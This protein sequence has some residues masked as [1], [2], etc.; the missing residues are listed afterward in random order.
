MRLPRI[1]KKALLDVRLSRSHAALH[2]ETRLAAEANR[3]NA[4]RAG[5][6][7]SP[8]TKPGYRGSE[9]QPVTY[10][11]RFVYR[12]PPG[13]DL[14]QVRVKGDFNAQGER[15]REWTSR[16]MTET[17][18]G[19]GIWT[20]DVPLV[21]RGQHEPWRYGFEQTL[22]SGHVST[23]AMSTLNP[24]T[25]HPA[26]RTVA[27]HSPVQYDQRGVVQVGD[28]LEFRG[29][30]FCTAEKVNLKILADGNKPEEK[31]PMTK[32]PNGLWTT[33]QAH[34]AADLM[35]RAY[36]YEVTENGQTTDWSDIYTETLQG[37]A[38]GVDKFFVHRPS[39]D[40][41]HEY[42][43][44]TDE[45]VHF[46][47]P[48]Q[49]N[50]GAKD[51]KLAFKDASGRQLSRR[52]L[53]E[54]IGSYDEPARIA[55][56]RK[57]AF[58]DLWSESAIDE[59]GR[60]TMVN[61]NGSGNFSTLINNPRALDGLH[62]EFQDATGQKLGEASGADRMTLA[63]DPWNRAL[64]P[65]S[66]RDVGA[67]IITPRLQPA[68]LREPTPSSLIYQLHPTSF[69]TEPANQGVDAANLKD[70]IRHF[71]FLKDSGVTDIQLLPPTQ[72]QMAKSWSYEGWNTMAQQTRLGF[73][74]GEG[75][76]ARWV[77]GAEALKIAT[78]EA[79][80]AGLNVII[81]VVLNHIYEPAKAELY[82]RS[83]NV[84]V[85]RDPNAPGIQT[86]DTDWGTA[87]NFADPCVTQAF[88]DY[89]HYLRNVIGVDG[90][91]F[92]FTEP[93]QA[94]GGADMLRR[95]NHLVRSFGMQTLVGEQFPYDFKLTAQHGD[96]LLF[97]HTLDLR[98]E[99]ALHNDKDNPA[100]LLKAGRGWDLN[101]D[102]LMDLITQNPSISGG[103]G[104]VVQGFTTHD[105][106]G[107][108]MR[109]LQAALGGNETHK[110]PRDAHAIGVLKW[111]HALALMSPGRAMF[112][113][114]DNSGATNPF[115]WGAPPT[116][117]EGGKWAE[118][119]KE[120]LQRWEPRR[121]A[122]SQERFLEAAR[123]T[124][125]PADFTAGEQNMVKYLRTLEPGQREE[126]MVNMTRVS[127]H[128]NFAALARLRESVPEL[129][130]GHFAAIRLF[131]HNADGVMAFRRHAQ[132]GDY[133]EV[134]NAKGPKSNYDKFRLPEGTWELVHNTDAA[135]Y[136]GEGVGGAVG[137]R[138]HGGQ[139]VSL[140]TG[141]LVLRK[142]G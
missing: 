22:N 96:G 85:D 135:E 70:V 56:A 33:G 68:K 86:F 71:K 60:I 128:E 98:T 69:M 120:Q 8:A 37:T 138:F 90:L 45:L 104:A 52:E 2:A 44:D 46:S 30:L 64:G 28:R 113:S 5:A 6:V 123:T 38:R 79:H 77:T 1:E 130:N 40:S 87:P 121:D 67:A 26:D 74:I 39:G 11:Q 29:F 107:N 84:W 117:G 115:K 49:F 4:D 21:D 34:S 81:D 103:F 118:Q 114:G 43:K 7:F 105:E 109:A 25:V 139:T 59:S 134:A 76:D 122:R 95:I 72:T 41:A 99:H 124:T 94:A 13:T 82:L 51:V 36:V 140:P 125:M 16:P 27:V 126:F 89:C 75:A 116:W 110:N 18:A 53:Q 83:K 14:R 92:D 65:M 73:T 10:S 136:G 32:G 78:E 54:R 57:G 127:I 142:V 19:S 112:F 129:A 91:R 31:F 3:Q 17:F 62:Y 119:T 55:T 88:I 93:I 9:Q 108:G 111:F 35:G 66:A 47:V 23:W 102:R 58:N 48:S 12:V 101:L 15:S 63:N 141:A 100:E 20:V 61:V 131:T 106:V 42:W 97:S 132:R 24:L 50:A 80:N 133:I 137:T